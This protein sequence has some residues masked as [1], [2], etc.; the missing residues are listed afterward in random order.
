MPYVPP[1]QPIPIGK[2]NTTA[3]GTPERITKNVAGTLTG[4]VDRSDD[5]LACTVKIR[6]KTGNTGNIYVGTAAVN[7]TT[8][9]GCYDILAAGQ[10]LIIE[11]PL[12]RGVF[13]PA[14]IWFDADNNTDVAIGFIQP[15]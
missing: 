1:S 12:G 10:E 4:N 15:T 6:A 2:L 13:K 11:D 9:A 14:D 8:F 3:F 5:L 7:R